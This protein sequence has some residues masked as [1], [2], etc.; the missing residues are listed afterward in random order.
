ME[1]DLLHL[2]GELQLSFGHNEPSYCQLSDC[3]LKGIKRLSFIFVFHVFIF[4]FLKNDI[5]PRVDRI[6][7]WSPAVDD[8]TVH[9]RKTAAE[10]PAL[11]AVDPDP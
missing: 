9:C 2:T 8:R 1:A 3:Q 10:I 5:V 11:I 6:S 7:I 4:I